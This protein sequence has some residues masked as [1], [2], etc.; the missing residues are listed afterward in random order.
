MILLG[1][2]TE[3]GVMRKAILTVVACTQLLCAGAVFAKPTTQQNCDKTRVLAWNAFRNCVD[4]VVAKN[5][6]GTTFDQQAALARCRH[7][8]FRKWATYQAKA[9]LTPSPCV[10]NRLTDNGDGSVTDNL[11]GLIWEKK[12]AADL[13][14]NLADPHDADNTYEWSSGAPYAGTGTA[15]TGFLK[16]LNTGAGF[17]AANDWRLPTLAELESLI[18]DYP[19]KGASGSVTCV[20]PS[21]PCI[22]PTFG[23]TVANAYWSRTKYLPAASDAWAVSFENQDATHSAKVS[24]QFVRAVRGGL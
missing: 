2:L 3:G 21:T 20:C 5:A 9:S 10:G 24:S 11:S 14:A 23:A 15:F 16:G 7:T 6:G 8:Y 22:D 4:A 19:C 13:A 1:V 12:T 17:L 18:L